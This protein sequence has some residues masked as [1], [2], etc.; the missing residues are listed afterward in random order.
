MTHRIEGQKAK[1]IN[2]KFEDAGLKCWFYRRLDSML[3]AAPA[4][5]LRVNRGADGNRFDD[6]LTL[7]YVKC[8]T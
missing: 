8:N 3:G 2:R 4:G 7:F 5:L 6:L 1:H